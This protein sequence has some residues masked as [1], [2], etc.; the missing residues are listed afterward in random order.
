MGH[1]L[2]ENTNAE[3]ILVGKTKEKRALGRHMRRWQNNMKLAHVNC[4]DLAQDGEIRLFQH[5]FVSKV[6]DD[7]S[8]SFW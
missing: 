2:G 7:C 8:T 5:K 4:T 3:G 6:S 1:V